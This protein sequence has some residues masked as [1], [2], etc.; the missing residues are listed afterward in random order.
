MG[1]WGFQGMFPEMG[2]GFGTL[3]RWDVGALG[4]KGLGFGGLGFGVL[5]FRGLPVTDKTYLFK[6]PYIDTKNKEP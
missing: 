5:G 2:L 3:G 1:L 6:E 4:S